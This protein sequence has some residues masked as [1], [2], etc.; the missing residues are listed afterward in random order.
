MKAE[1]PLGGLRSTNSR[2]LNHYNKTQH[3]KV[4]DIIIFSAP[5]ELVLENEDRGHNFANNLPNSLIFG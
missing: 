4:F 1:A 5:Y 2:T 3:C